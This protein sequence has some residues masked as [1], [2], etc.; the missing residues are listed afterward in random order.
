MSGSASAA[1]AQ[2][3]TLVATF[4]VSPGGLS[5]AVVESQADADALTFESATQ[6]TV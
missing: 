1:P 4:F 2:A 5:A 3:T 6:Y